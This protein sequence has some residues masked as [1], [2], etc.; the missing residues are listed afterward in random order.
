[1]I[2]KSTYHRLN[3]CWK[4]T[5]NEIPTS[6]AFLTYI[7]NVKDRVLT[8]LCKHKAGISNQELIFLIHFQQS[9]CSILGGTRFFSITIKNLL[10]DAILGTHF[11]VKRNFHRAQTYSSCT[12]EYF[13]FWSKIRYFLP[14]LVWRTYLIDLIFYTLNYRI[15]S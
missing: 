11:N 12:A 4:N 9:L 10:A 15:L 7:N 14:S 5:S 6:M 8:I 3:S 1:M 2:I 13:V